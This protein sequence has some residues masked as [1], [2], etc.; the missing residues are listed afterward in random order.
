M[1]PRQ[2]RPEPFHSL[3]FLPAAYPMSFTIGPPKSNLTRPRSR[4]IAAPARDGAESGSSDGDSESSRDDIAAASPPPAGSRVPSGG[5]QHLLSPQAVP[6]AH[7]SSGL[8]S[9]AAP[10]DPAGT[11]RWTP[12]GL[13]PFASPLPSPTG[14]HA[15]LLGVSAPSGLTRTPSM[16]DALASPPPR[17]MSALSLGVPA[18]VAATRSVRSVSGP[19]RHK[20]TLLTEDP[21][22]PW[23]AQRDPS[24]R[25]VYVV[26]WLGAY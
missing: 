12:G 13:N 16:R 7:R 20:S 2:A 22:K 6:I 4:T 15:D 21:V 9:F 25:S 8:L 10:D 23:R 5:S 19:K 1:R 3:S 26:I 14:S 18:S 11:G 24:A 17:G